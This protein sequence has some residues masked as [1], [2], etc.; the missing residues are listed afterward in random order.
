M[1]DSEW[2]NKRLEWRKQKKTKKIIGEQLRK[3]KINAKI[4]TIYK[5]D[6]EKKI[7]ITSYKRIST[8][9]SDL[10]NKLRL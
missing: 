5:V 6:N 1:R 3:K 9:G 4:K 7:L 10:V 8:F 2:G